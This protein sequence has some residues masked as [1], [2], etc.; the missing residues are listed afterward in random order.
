MAARLEV[1]TS[2]LFNAKKRPKFCEWSKNK[3]P[4]AKAWQWVAESK[5]FMP[6][7]IPNP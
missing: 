3:D 2:T 5:H 4:E 6:F 1:K 7:K